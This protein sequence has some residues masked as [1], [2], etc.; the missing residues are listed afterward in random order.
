MK[1]SPSTTAERFR[2]H[3]RD[4]AA[5][6]RQSLWRRSHERFRRDL[7]VHPHLFLGWGAFRVAELRESRAALLDALRDEAVWTL[8][9]AARLVCGVGLLVAQDLTCY[10]T[11]AALD[12]AAAR[13]LVAPLPSALVDVAPL[14]PRAAILI[15]H[16]AEP[17]PPSFTLESGH[18]VLTWH[19]FVA[20]VKGTIGWRPDLLTRLEERY[21]RCQQARMA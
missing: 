5:H 13:A 11:A 12:R 18:R 6:R 21:L 4:L 3:Q 19:A 10:L 15:A 20:D 17:A 14:L 16:V 7:A 2:R 9:T 8:D 1:T